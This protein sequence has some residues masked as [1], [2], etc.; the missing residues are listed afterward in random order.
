MKN[1]KSKGVSTNMIF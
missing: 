1:K